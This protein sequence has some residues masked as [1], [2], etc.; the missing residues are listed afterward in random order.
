MRGGLSPFQ[1]NGLAASAAANG[2]RDRATYGLYEQTKGSRRQVNLDFGARIG[3]AYRRKMRSDA[4]VLGRNFW[5]ESR[6]AV[7]VATSR[8]SLMVRRRG[9]LAQLDK[10][11]PPK[12]K[13][14]FESSRVRQ[15]K[16]WRGLGSPRP[17]R[18]GLLAL[19]SPP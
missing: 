18:L 17:L 8:K 6:D 1:G 3:D 13:V 14:D 4:V 2:L 5:V 12:A 10:A 9:P 16:G 11:L 19:K 7:T 15:R